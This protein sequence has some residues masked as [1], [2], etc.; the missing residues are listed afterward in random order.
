MRIAEVAYPLPVDRTFDYEVPSALTGSLAPGAR[1]LAPF[2]PRTLC[3]VV[4]GVREGVSERPLKAIVAVP[5]PEPIL[6][7][8]HVEL[9]RWLSGRYC[10]PIGECLKVM[11]PANLR[12][13]RR[14]VSGEAPGAEPAAGH[15]ERDPR[16]PRF[17]LTKSQ[18]D[19]LATLSDRLR[20]RRFKATLLFGVPASGKTEVYMRLIRRALAEGGQALFLVPEISLTRPFYKEFAAALGLPVARW[21]SKISVRERRRVW[22]GMRSGAV[23]VVV[24]ARSASLLPLKD[25]RLAVLDEE[26][27]ESYKQDDQAPYYH[28]RDVVLH[29]ARRF[30]ATVVLGSATP[31]IEAF[32][33]TGAGGLELLQMPERV[34]KT[35]QRPPVRILARAAAEA[36]CLS[37]ELLDGIKACLARRDQVILLVNRR[38]YSNFIICRKCGWVA[39]CPTCAV[40]FIHHRAPRHETAGGL[41]ESSASGFHLRCHHCGARAE[42]PPSCGRCKAGPLRF[43][44][45]G[46]QKVV[47]E[48]VSA[49]PGV[50]VLR[51]DRD[52]VAKESVTDTG[53]Y[54]AFSAGRA[55]VLVGTKLV[56]KG[57]HFPRVTLVG[58]VDADTMLNMPDFRS[59]ERTVQMLV[60]AAGRAGRAER[61]GE[62]ILQ[63]SQPTHYAIQAV[64]RGDYAFFAR[65]EIGFRKEL[66]YPPAS[67]LVRL[68]FSG[69]NEKA[70]LKATEATARHLRAA[71]GEADEVLGPAPGVH[72]RL[73]GRFRYHLLLK[74]DDEARVGR[75]L[76]A[77]RELKLPS[78]VRIKVNV[79]P[80]DFF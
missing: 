69:K 48:L 74:V 65:Q 72:A 19:A 38:G 58:V 10:A 29:R 21:H 50:R 46:T 73:H 25:L 1:V 45:I 52:T 33:R 79:D 37:R 47:S 39:R 67:T 80:Y 63:T 61:P 13:A 66:H 18:A 64:A 8:E 5:D 3:G 51:M 54:E 60:Q 53:I 76:D 43:A 56:A 41:F 77:V 30:G 15:R 35:T 16:A 9:A 22:L 17:Q 6:S 78:T 42:V 71:F 70:V 34:S 11:I 55:D 75:T 36:R 57:F 24:G 27:D 20:E 26:Q 12:N 40:A 2:G 62:V 28:A 68:V 59:A 23:R 49:L 31:S 44:G 14:P 7:E 4:M 32:A